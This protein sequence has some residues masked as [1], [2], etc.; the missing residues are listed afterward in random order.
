MS[1]ELKTEI[2]SLVP[3]LRRFAA[4]L[5]GN[6][7]DGDDL[8][9]QACVKALV[10]LGQFEPGTRLDRWMMRIVQTT[11]LDAVRSRRRRR[12]EIDPEALERLSDEGRAA[13]GTEHRMV[14]DRVRAAMA[15]LPEDQRAVLALVAIEGYSYKEAAEILE[16]PVGTVMSRLSRAR[17]RLLP[18]IEDRGA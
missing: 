1:D 5:T 13:S 7:E 4:A 12:T 3:R 6:R 15:T 8:V 14:L 17:G 11:F 9:Q 18:L 16:V 2:A 10:R